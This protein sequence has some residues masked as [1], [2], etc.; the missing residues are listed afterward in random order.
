MSDKRYIQVTGFI[1]L[2]SNMNLTL[3]SIHFSYRLSFD[4]HYISVTGVI[5]VANL[6]LDKHDI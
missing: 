5:G 4:T 2:L 6:M 3:P 1:Y